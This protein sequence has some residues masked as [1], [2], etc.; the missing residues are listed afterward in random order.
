[1][2]LLLIVLDPRLFHFHRE[3][4]ADYL[5][6][7]EGAWWDHK[8]TTN[9]IIFHDESSPNE[10]EGFKMMSFCKTTLYKSQVY[11]SLLF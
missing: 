2:V 6:F 10:I 5:S 7:G 1:M 8:T 4:I 3:M 9:E 11:T